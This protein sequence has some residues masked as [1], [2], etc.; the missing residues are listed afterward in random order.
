MRGLKDRTA[1]VTGAGRGIGR[2]IALR[3]AREGARV[4]VNDLLENRAGETTARI[5][6]ESGEAATVPGDV[7]S[8]EESE[9]IV[10]DAA[11]A[12]G[13]V[14]ILVNNAG[15]LPDRK[16]GRP[17]PAEEWDRTLAI[18]LRSVMLMCQAVLPSM[19]AERDG[20]IVN[21]AS[22]AGMVGGLQVA[23]DYAASKGAILAYTKTLARQE[24]RYGIRANCVAPSATESPMTERFTELQRSTVLAAIPLGRFGTPEEIAAA[25]AFLA[26]DEASFITG[27]TLPVTGGQVM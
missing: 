25:V 19:R 16:P 8:P 1:F 5:L 3:L 4:A 24:A 2:A 11:A 10:R 23:A 6:R 21:I 14:S 17:V 26:S 20:R 13:P 22:T 12:L 7:S 9:Q 18:N 27:A 15:I